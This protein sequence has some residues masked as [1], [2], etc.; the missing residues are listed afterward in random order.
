MREGKAIKKGY[1]QRALRR[2][3]SAINLT[4]YVKHRPSTIFADEV[5]E[6]PNL[7]FFSRKSHNKGLSLKKFVHD[8]KADVAYST[9]VYV[10]S[11][12]KCT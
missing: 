6:N 1:L 12:K 7:N 10:P 2:K 8:T 3:E 5:Y 4:R 9:V 11:R